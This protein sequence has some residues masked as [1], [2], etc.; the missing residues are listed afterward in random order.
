MVNSIDSSLNPDNFNLKPLEHEEI[1]MGHLGPKSNPQTEKIF[2]T[3]T[4]PSSSGRD[5]ECDIIDG[6]IK[7][8]RYTE[9]LTDIT[10][11]QV[12]L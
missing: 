3:S 12:F 9:N 1:F 8:L 10:S 2:W 4:P 5:R 6:P 7:S 11:K